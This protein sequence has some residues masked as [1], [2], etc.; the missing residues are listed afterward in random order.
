MIGVVADFKNGGVNN[1]LQASACVPYP[2]DAQ[3]NPGITLR[4]RAA[5]TSARTTPRASAPSPALL[6]ATAALAS[7]LPLRRALEIDPLDALRREWGYRPAKG[8]ET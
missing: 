6:A 3:R 1:K 5:P 8:V 7:Y 4:T 2:Y